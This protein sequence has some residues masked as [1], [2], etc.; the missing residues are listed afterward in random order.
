M[1]DFFDSSVLIAAVSE[2][3]G[4]HTASLAAWKA[5]RPPLVY[6]HGLLEC[7]ST[8]T[9]QRHPAQ[10]TPDEATRLLTRN[11]EY[12]KA[13]LIELSVEDVMVHLQQAQKLGVRGGAVYDYMHLCAARSAN[14]TRLFTLNK[15]HFS[16]IAP[17]LSPIIFH[18]ADLY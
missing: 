5:A 9:G 12:S 17:D 16:A 8:L 4:E 10:L 14:A 13:R 7:F 11:L 1:A 2:D 18:P 15:R 3:D 6:A